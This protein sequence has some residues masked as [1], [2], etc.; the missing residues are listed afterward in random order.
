[1]G[2]YGDERNVVTSNIADHQTSSYSSSSYATYKT[3]PK[4]VPL[5][6][7]WEFDLTTL[8]WKERVQYPQLARSYHSLV[9]WPDGRIAAFGGFQQDNNIGGE[10]V[11]FVF[12]DLIVNRANE[13]HWLKLLSPYNQIANWQKYHYKTRTGISNRLEHTAVL[14]QFGSMYVWGG[15]FQTVHQVSGMWRLDVFNRDARLEFELAQPDGIEQY[16]EELE[17]LHM[18]IAMM[19][20]ASLTLSSFFSMIQQRRAREAAEEGNGGSMLPRRGGL[21]RRVIDSLPLKNYD[22]S[23]AA[24]STSSD[25]VTL[26]EEECCPIC[27]A[28]KI[29]MFLLETLLVSAI[30]SNALRYIIFCNDIV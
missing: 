1:M 2:S 3:S 17:A 19:M 21:T 25:N 22:A 16:E 7:T 23:E 30:R 10:T 11:A 20:F 26:Q 13:T 24:E 29:M 8:K 6:D 4:W 9:G 27:L 14:D 5:S 28:G 18:F 15:R 12:K